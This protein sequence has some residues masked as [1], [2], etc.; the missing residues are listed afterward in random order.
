MTVM[1]IKIGVLHNRY[2]I[3]NFN[4]KKKNVKIITRK[5]YEV[6][7]KLGKSIPYIYYYIDHTH[8]TH[9]ISCFLIYE[10]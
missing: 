4:N 6:F 9:T 2:T 3:H 1:I 10:I 7:L 8:I 5:E